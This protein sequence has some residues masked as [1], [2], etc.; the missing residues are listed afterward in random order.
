MKIIG[1]TGGMGSGKSY[2]SSIISGMNGIPVID[3]DKVYHSLIG[4]RGELP[5][6]LAREYGETI[7]SEDGGVNRKALGEMVFSDKVKLDRLSQITHP[8]VEKEVKSLL[9]KYESEGYSAVL[10]EVPL[11]FESGFDRMCD[12]IICVVSPLEKRIQKIMER[13][14]LDEESVKMRIKSQKDDDFYIAKSSI[15]LYNDY[16]EDLSEKISEIFRKVTMHFIG[17]PH[18]RR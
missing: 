18:S 5:N 1:I 7:L 8:E 11:M 15:S 12:E 14:G 13:S 3:T 2:V 10:V 4:T 9:K 6:A 16:T 17:S